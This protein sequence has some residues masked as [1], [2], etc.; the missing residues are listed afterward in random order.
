MTRLI[1]DSTTDIPK[2]FVEGHGILVL[3][4]HV[5]IEDTEYLD[6]VTIRTNEVY[7]KMRSGILPRTAQISITD[8]LETFKACLD[9]GEDIL[10]LAFSAKMSG[11]CQLA[12]SL[13]EEL[14]ADYPDRRLLTLDSKGGSFATGLIAMETAKTLAS[15]ASFDE[16]VS[17]ASYL[18]DH[19]EHVFC[20]TDLLWMIRGG[21][22]SRTMG[23]T[24]AIL[25]IKP[26]LDVDDGEMEVIQKVRGRRKALERVAE[27]VAERAA[28]CPDQVIGITHADDI[29]TAVYMQELISRRLPKATFL[30]EQIGAVLGVHIG[31]GG[32]GVFFFNEM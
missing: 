22:I 26:V 11:T 28:K 5:I 2:N 20:I 23:Y 1:I 24:A 10:Y 9:R 30:I 4:L 8:T 18:I 17:R 3:P 27:I 29:E 21:R 31:I 12:A 15:G 32:V 13:M 19:V 16:A 25:S 7:D 14:R 6:G